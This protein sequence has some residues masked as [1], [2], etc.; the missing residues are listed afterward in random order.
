GA[1]L[2][3]QVAQDDVLGLDRARAYRAA[4]ADVLFVEAPASLEAVRRIPA[5]VDGLHLLN[6]VEGGKTPAIER[7]TA[8]EWG[9][10]AV[11]YANAAM[12]AAWA[13]ADA[14]LRHLALHGS[15][16]DVLDRLYG[17][18]ERQ[19]LVGKPFY[20]DLSARYAR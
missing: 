16:T 17:W 3:L 20:D 9:Y 8:G 10:A 19:E 18:G 12:R 5:E 11:L 7:A 2:L 6:I 4:G 13:G 1:H 15:T 14:V